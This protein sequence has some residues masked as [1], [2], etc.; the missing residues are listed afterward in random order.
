MSANSPCTP[1][2]PTA[3]HRDRHRRTSTFIFTCLLSLSR[4]LDLLPAFSR[5][6]GSAWSRATSVYIFFICLFCFST[7]R[8]LLMHFP[9]VLNSCHTLFSSCFILPLHYINRV[10]YNIPCT[11]LII[12]RN[13]F[14]YP[15]KIHSLYI[16]K[17]SMFNASD[18]LIK[19]C[20]ESS[21]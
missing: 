21:S 2:C 8:T 15:T 3:L 7:K 6:T 5:I 20:S 14:K 16:F 17:F 1:H 18:I 10:L 12:A 9:N 4:S 19:I 13:Y 11:D